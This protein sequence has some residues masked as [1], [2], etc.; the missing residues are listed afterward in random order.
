[1]RTSLVLSS[2]AQFPASGTVCSVRLRVASWREAEQSPG[3]GSRLPA[4]LTHTRPRHVFE[5]FP[6]GFGDPGGPSGAGSVFPGRRWRRCPCRPRVLAGSPQLPVP[7]AAVTIVTLFLF[8]ASVVEI[9]SGLRKK[10]PLVMESTC[11]QPPARSAARE[12]ASPDYLLAWVAAEDP[13]T[14]QTVS[15]RDSVKKAPWL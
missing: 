14:W 8:P 6:P 1:M 7:H 3:I 13:R 4:F 2:F 10:A 9:L 5:R 15:R 12:I 11:I